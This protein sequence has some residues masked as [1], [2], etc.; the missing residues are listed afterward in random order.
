MH[1]QA[2]AV[3]KSTTTSIEMSRKYAFFPSD[4]RSPKRASTVSRL[5]GLDRS[6]SLGDQRSLRAAL[7]SGV[8]SALTAMSYLLRS[9]CGQRYS[10]AGRGVSRHERLPLR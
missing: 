9:R 6:I 1:E 3:E 5:S 2:F 4:T 7:S 8:R 10:L